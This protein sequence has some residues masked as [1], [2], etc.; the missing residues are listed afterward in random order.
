MNEHRRGGGN[1][2]KYHGYWQR[3]VKDFMMLTDAP[4]GV[5]ASELWLAIQPKTESDNPFVQG[6]HIHTCAALTETDRLYVHWTIKTEPAKVY[7]ET[8]DK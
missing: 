5:S 4:V 8:K 7:E 1:S 6:F 2:F 3:H